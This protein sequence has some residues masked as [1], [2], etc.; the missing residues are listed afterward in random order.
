M[1]AHWR[2]MDKDYKTEITFSRDEPDKEYKNSFY[3]LRLHYTARPKNYSTEEIT[4]T[5]ENRNHELSKR[6]RPKN[7]SEASAIL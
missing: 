6:R 5:L 3:F 1:A 4:N 2:W 7:R